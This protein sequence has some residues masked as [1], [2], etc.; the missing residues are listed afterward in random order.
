[1]LTPLF[2]M[3]NES[4]K[5]LFKKWQNDIACNWQNVCFSP[6]LKLTFHCNPII[7]YWGNPDNAH[8]KDFFPSSA[9]VLSPT[10][11]T[12]PEFLSLVII[13]ASIVSSTFLRESPWHVRNWGLNRKNKQ[14]TV[15]LFGSLIQ[16]LNFAVFDLSVFTLKWRWW[17]LT[18]RAIAW[19]KIVSSV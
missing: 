16:V 13:L 11:Y 1:M 9:W 8:S 4:S 19:I 12:W 5:R 14:N 3:E 2:Q 6:T 7:Y 15:V 17:Y 18:R 10:S